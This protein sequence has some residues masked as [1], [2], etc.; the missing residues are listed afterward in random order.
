[1]AFNFR[2]QER[3][4]PPCTAPIS[5]ARLYRECLTGQLP[6]DYLPTAEREHLIYELWSCGWTD[7]EIATHARLTTYTTGR[8]RGRLGLAAHPSTKGA[9]A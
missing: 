4:Q 8:I 3:G 1:V 6:A 2:T 7:V 5:R 9:V